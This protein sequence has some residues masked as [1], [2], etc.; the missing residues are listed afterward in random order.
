VL[1]GLSSA[2][3]WLSSSAGLWG[4]S[5]A[6]L[7]GACSAVLRGSSSA[8]A[9][10]KSNVKGSPLTAVFLHSA[11]AVI[12]GGVILDH[13][14]LANMDGASWCKYYGVKV[15]RGIATVYKAVNDKWTTSRGFDYSPGAKP[16]CNDFRADNSCGG[17]LHFGPT[18]SHA[19]AYFSSATKFVAVGVKVSELQP[20]HQ[21]GEVAKC[22]APR[23][24]RAAV[25]V[26]IYGK[27]IA[28]SSK[29]AA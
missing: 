29:E 1:W 8:H 3:L 18:P 7:R 2:E 10:D 21:D 5:S 27:V 9:Y 26:D 19:K 23:V 20:I 14:N 6:G 25:E 15:S 11:T 13:S 12:S 16:S 4:L 17:G 22:K 24:V 28:P